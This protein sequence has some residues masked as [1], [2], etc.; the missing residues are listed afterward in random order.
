[1]KRLMLVVLF[2]SIAIYAQNAPSPVLSITFEVKCKVLPAKWNRFIE[3]RHALSLRDISQ[4]ILMPL[5]DAL[6]SEV[7]LTS[8]HRSRIHNKRVG[9]AYNSLH[10]QGRALDFVVK[11]YSSKQVYDYLIC[12]GIEV[13]QIFDEGDHI[14][15]AL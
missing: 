12:T 9:G 8:G 3:N 7:I 14:H 15:I 2:M 13:T 6:K 4:D 1:M 10:I 11:G 5:Q